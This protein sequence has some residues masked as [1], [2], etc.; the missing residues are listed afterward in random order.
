MKTRKSDSKPQSSRSTRRDEASAPPQSTPWEP[1]P[2]Y[3]PVPEMPVR[4]REQQI[5]Q[6]VEQAGSSRGVLIIQ[7]GDES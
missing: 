7:Y 3:V 5:D 6:D 4:P 1:V 2:L